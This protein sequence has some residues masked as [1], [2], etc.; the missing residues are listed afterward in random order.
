VALNLAFAGRPSLHYEHLFG[1]GANDLP[2][3]I[4][5]RSDYGMPPA[6]PR[7]DPLPVVR[8]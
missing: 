7:I 8:S 3:F 4:L 1:Q 6:D 5:R 2:G